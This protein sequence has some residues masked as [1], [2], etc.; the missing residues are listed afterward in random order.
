MQQRPSAQGL[1]KGHNSL[2]IWE[3]AQGFWGVLTCNLSTEH[4]SDLHMWSKGNLG[5]CI[6]VNPSPY[7]RPNRIKLMGLIRNTISQSPNDDKDK[8]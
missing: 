2:Q 8:I 4:L 1:I 3:N 7:S 5:Q 6:V